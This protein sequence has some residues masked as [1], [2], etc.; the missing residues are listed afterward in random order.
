MYENFVE[1]LIPREWFEEEQRRRT[2]R[3]AKLHRRKADPMLEPRRVA[4]RHLLTDLVYCGA[5]EG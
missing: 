5:I 1:P 4:S 3:A 2:E